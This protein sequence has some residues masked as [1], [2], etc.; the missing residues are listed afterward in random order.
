MVMEVPVINSFFLKH[1]LY[2][3]YMITN[4]TLHVP[5]LTHMPA[6]TLA[7]TDSKRFLHLAKDFFRGLSSAKKIW[8]ICSDLGQRQGKL[9]MHLWVHVV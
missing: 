9:I 6:L 3:L 4:T 2:I 7:M 5:G 1:I 8:R